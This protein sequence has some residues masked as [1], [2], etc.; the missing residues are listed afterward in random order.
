MARDELDLETLERAIA[1]I[2]KFAREELKV[3]AIPIVEDAYWTVAGSD[4][5]DFSR[6]PSQM[7]VGSLRDDWELVCGAL[8]RDGALVPL[9]LMHVAPLLGYLAHSIPSYSTPQPDAG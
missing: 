2:F 7:N 5:Y 1:S 9:T 4:K 3:S 8:D 6:E